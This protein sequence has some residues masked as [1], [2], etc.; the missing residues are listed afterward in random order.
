[1][2]DALKKLGYDGEAIDKIIGSHAVNRFTL[3][4]LEKKLLILL[5]ILKV[6]VM[7]MNKLFQ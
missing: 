4:T 7:M 5:L 2:A 1:M 3:N 6:L